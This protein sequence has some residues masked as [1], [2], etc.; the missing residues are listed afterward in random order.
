M[1]ELCKK[2]NPD[3]I[4]MNW[5]KNPIQMKL[6]L[7]FITAPVIKSKKHLGY[8]NG[9]TLYE[10]DTIKLYIT[11]GIVNGTEYLDHI[12]YGKNL[13]NPYNN[14]V[15]PFYLS[16]IM[17]KEGLDFFK[18]YYKKDIEKILSDMREKIKK[19]LAKV[20][21]DG[22]NEYIIPRNFQV[23]THDIIGINTLPNGMVFNG[24]MAGGDWEQPIFYIVYWDGKSLRGYIP[25]DGNPYNRST[26]YAYGNNGEA[27]GLS[28]AQDAFKNFGTPIV[29]YHNHFDGDMEELDCD[30]E[31]L[32]PDIEKIKQDI[33]GRI[34]PK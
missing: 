27:D 2:L 31:S 28:D 8:E 25:T 34:V 12:L 4:K 16:D 7:S 30:H 15:N 9:W 24:V 1:N 19:D 17:T 11:G 6:F 10:N 23:D 20:T 29:K 18:D 22:E 3:K 5:N 32:E 13:A 26:K 33:M 21:F 14:Y